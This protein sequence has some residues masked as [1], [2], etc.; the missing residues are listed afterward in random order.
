MVYDVLYYCARLC[1]MVAPLAGAKINQIHA[2]QCRPRNIERFTLAVSVLPSLL[3][4]IAQA[5]ANYVKFMDSRS[6]DFGTSEGLSPILSLYGQSMYTYCVC[7]YLYIYIYLSL[8]T[9][10]HINQSI[11][12]YKLYR[13]LY[14]YMYTI[15]ERSAIG[16][17][18]LYSSSLPGRIPPLT[19]S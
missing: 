13:L 19:S 6:E 16:D 12:R 2:F 10:I 1:T 8:S 17:S 14:K 11:Y 3:T 5:C 9:L 15:W 4:T 18:F 7:I